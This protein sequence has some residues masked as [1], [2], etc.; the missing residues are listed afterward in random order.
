MKRRLSLATAAALGALSI[1][2][3][4]SAATVVYK[5]DVTVTSALG[6]GFSAPIFDY[7]NLSDPGV[8]IA[9]A[10]IFN[11]APWDYVLNRTT[12]PYQIINPAGGSRTLLEGQESAG[13][14]N[15]GCTPGIKYGFTSFDPGDTF[16]FAADPETG[17]CGNAVVDVRPF[18]NNNLMS[19]TVDFGGGVVLTGNTWTLEYINPNASRALDANQRYRLSLQTTVTTNPPPPPPVGG[20]PEPA[21]WAL[22]ISGFGMAGAALRRRSRLAA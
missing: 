22:M 3:S 4:T 10:R 15:D 14:P 20:V 6:A 8:T 1:A 17:G 13:N 19:A 7:Y 2:S 21:T 9:S 5:F 11:G 18:L 12:A 16:H